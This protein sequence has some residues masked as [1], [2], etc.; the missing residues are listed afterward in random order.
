MTDTDII[1]AAA[2]A[3]Y[4]YGH[5]RDAYDWRHA[6]EPERGQAR[7]V[8]AAVLAAVMPMIEARALERAAAVAEGFAADSVPSTRKIAA[9]IRALVQAKS[10]SA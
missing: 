6:G 5:H 1:E 9:A 3:L 8:A 2:Q 7:E 4:E 10:S